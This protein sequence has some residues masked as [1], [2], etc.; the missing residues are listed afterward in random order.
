MVLLEIS[1]LERPRRLLD[2]IGLFG[3]PPHGGMDGACSLA[4]MYESLSSA[5]FCRRKSFPIASE[6]TFVLAL[7]P[8]AL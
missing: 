1:G 6:F 7:S 3:S 2:A 5:V 8:I 4:K